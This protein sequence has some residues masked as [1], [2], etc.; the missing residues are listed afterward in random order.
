[1]GLVALGAVITFWLGS[2]TTAYQYGEDPREIL[3]EHE[4]TEALTPAAVREAARRYLRMDNYVH[5]TLL[6]VAPNM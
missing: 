3:R 5:V 2:I 1:M 4:M 6:P